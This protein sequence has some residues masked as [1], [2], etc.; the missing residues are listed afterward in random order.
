MED[1]IMTNTSQVQSGALSRRIILLRSVACAAG[2]AALLG[3]AR[4]ANAAKMAQT[5]AA[6]AY[7]DSPKGAQQCDNCALF[8][9]PNSCKVVDGT[10][11]PSGWCKLWAKKAG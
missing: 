7:Q 4:Y 8:E 10:I 9:A 2:A 3:P 6:V 1:V 11:A 5:A